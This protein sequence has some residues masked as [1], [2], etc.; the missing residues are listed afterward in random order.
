LNG[1]KIDAVRIHDHR[2]EATLAHL[3]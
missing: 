2:H 3:S 1:D